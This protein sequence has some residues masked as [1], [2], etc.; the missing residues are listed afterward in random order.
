MRPVHWSGTLLLVACASAAGAQSPPPYVAIRPPASAPAV[1]ALERPARLSVRDARLGDALTSLYEQSGVPVSF[2]PSRLPM[3]LRVTC[4]CEGAT[5]GEVLQQ[6]LDRT[7]FSYR[8]IEGN[9]LIYERLSTPPPPPGLEPESPAERH[10]LATAALGVLHRPAAMERALPHPTQGTGSVT[11]VVTGSGGRPLAG[12]SLLVVGTTRGGQSD[13]QGRY[14]IAGVP[15]GI[16]T[17]RA[18]FAGHAE[19]VRQVTIVSGQAVTANIA[20][21][22]EVL[23]LEGVVAVGYGTRSARDLTG[24]IAA[25]DAERLA[26][27]PVPSVDQALAGQVAGVQVLQTNGVPGGGPQIQIRGIGAIGAGSEPLFVVDGFALPDASGAVRN[28]LADIPPQDIESVTVLKDASSAAIYGSRAANGVVVIT[29]KRGRAQPAR[30]QVDVLTGFQQIPGWGRPDMMNAREFARFHK[31]RI[32]DQIRYRD[33]R[34]PTLADIPEEYRNPEQYGEGTDWF[35]LMTRTAPMHELNASISGGTSSISAYVSGGFLRQEGVVLGS[36]FDRYSVRA[37]VSADLSDR[38]QVG[39][40]VA[41]TYT[42]RNLLVEGDVGRGIGVGRTLVM[43]PLVG[44]RNDDGSLREMVGSAG[45]IT[46]PN[47]LLYVQDVEDVTRALRG[48]GTAFAELELLEGLRVR[49]SANLDIS[50]GRTRT[51]TPSTIGVEGGS[52]PRIP[53]GGYST[54][55]YVNWLVEN[56]ASFRRSFGSAHTVDVLAGTSTQAHN[57]E[58]GDFTGSNF[59]DDDIRTLNAAAQITGGSDIQDWG[60]VSY[61][62]R[63]NYD[64]A[65]RYFVTA[66]LR[67]DGS[68][69]F[70]PGNRWGTFP[71]ASVA[72]RL[73][74]ESFLRDVGWIDD[75]KVRAS[76]GRTGNNNLGNYA[77]VGR[78]GT[79]NYVQGG[80]LATGRI[81][82]SLGN[83]ELG[84]EKTEEINVGLDLTVLDSRVT[85]TAEAYQGDTEDLLLDVQVP[86]SSG[87]SSVAMN[88][89]SVRNRGLELGFHT[90]NVDRESFRWTSDLNVAMNRNEVLALDSKDGVIHSFASGAGPAGTPSH[91]TRVGKPVGMFF[92]Y[93]SEGIYRDEADIRASGGFPGAIPGNVKFRDINGDGTITPI[94]DSEI[95]GNPYP[96]A[97]FG[98]NNTVT[99]GRVE[100]SVVASGQIGGDRLQVIRNHTDNLDGVFNVHRRM[101]NRWRSA[102]DPGDGKTPTPTGVPRGRQLYRSVSSLWVQDATHLSVR[103]ATLRYALPDRLLGMATQGASVYVSVQN[104]LMFTGYDGN[105]EASGYNTNTSALTPGVDYAPYPVPRTVTV[106]TRFG[107]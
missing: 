89:G 86:Q 87:F 37:N 81:L 100:L 31:E 65:S 91:I 39:L 28:P 6:L 5:V 43:S 10:L 23:Q 107:I 45:N 70:A 20:L 17:L 94:A 3:N 96:D 25:V 29:T 4:D 61:L 104:A 27:L 83:E 75:L 71:S 19:A 67:A 2:S 47:P 76:Y 7:G 79:A 84:W 34:E 15:T 46:I 82:G 95:I 99:A 51:F 68:S 72:W 97:T 105:P 54:T 73:S 101:L 36:D 30:I 78:I 62:A 59:P 88:T 74:E 24:A 56:T 92:G 77:Y 16:R 18:T 38:L 93:V 40:N 50:D 35:G 66:T 26:A 48:L 58:S 42:R 32:E 69:R 44:P 8:V 85:L 60:L 90:V 11:G 102:E 80:G 9:V 13:A 1:P 63:V 53:F 14:T 21:T 52:P 103:N 106:G 49:S 64:F 55:S 98:V 12:A 33:R 41:P 57:A 22:A